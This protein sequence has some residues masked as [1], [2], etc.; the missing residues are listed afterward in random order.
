MTSCGLL[1]THMYIEA[2]R[3]ENYR[4]FVDFSMKFREGLNVIIGANNSGKTG[5]LRTICLLNRPE[6]ITVDD[7]NKNK[8]LQYKELYLD[9]PPK[10]VIEYTIRHLI[11][12]SVQ[13]SDEGVIRLLP[14]IAMDD[15]RQEEAGSGECKTYALRAEL[16]AI[17]DLNPK[18]FEEFKTCVRESSDF[19]DFVLRLNRFI[20]DGRYGWRYEN[21]STGEEV[22]FILSRTAK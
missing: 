1:V 9:E 6:G 8:L 13:A 10:I 17:Y 14:L 5:L 19:Q 18:F 12:E 7:F 21:A 15:V 16:R 20:K 2:I 22:D 3:I 11:K 4:N